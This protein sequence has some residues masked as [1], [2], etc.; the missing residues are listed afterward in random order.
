MH[1]RLEALHPTIQKIL[2]IS[3]S[4]ALSL[5]VLHHGN[6]V[7][8]AHLGHRNENDHAP[9][10][11]NTIYWI[12]SLTKVLTSTAVAQ[13]VHKGAL[14]WDVPIRDYLPSAF[15]KTKLGLRRLCEISCL[16]EL[17]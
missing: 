1:Q 3:G 17:D 9:P 15:D 7:H 5:G 14:D 11:N 12:A 6:V 4:P 16:V 10:D 8:T 2:T 13:L